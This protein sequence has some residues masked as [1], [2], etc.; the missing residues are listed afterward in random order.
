[1]DGRLDVVALGSDGKLKQRALVGSIWG[2]DWQD[3]G[4]MA[5][6][7]PLAV[8]YKPTA[9]IGVF[10]LDDSGEVLRG[11]YRIDADGSWQVMSAFRS[12]G[13]NFSQSY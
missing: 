4:V 11:D 9:S 7:A 6:S 2:K 10:A 5:R 3:L 12:I 1:M 8:D 13:G